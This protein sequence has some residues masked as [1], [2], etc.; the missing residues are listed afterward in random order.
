[1]EP[2]AEQVTT[3]ENWLRRAYPDATVESHGYFDAEVRAFRARVPGS[4]G[5]APE[6]AVSYLVFEDSSGDEV[7][8]ALDRHRAAE[9]LRRAP[10]TRLLLGRGLRLGTAPAEPYR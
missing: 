6:V 8:A 7:V 10:E 3:V 2:T 1:M 5:P 4:R 9:I